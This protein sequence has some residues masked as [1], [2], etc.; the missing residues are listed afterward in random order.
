[1]TWRTSSDGDRRRAAS[2]RG[3]VWEVSDIAA[4]HLRSC[5]EPHGSKCSGVQHDA[6]MGRGRGPSSLAAVA[7]LARPRMNEVWVC[8]ATVVV[9]VLLA[10]NAKISGDVSFNYLGCLRSRPVGA[11]A[12]Q[13][14]CPA[15]SDRRCRRRRHHRR[16]HPG[17]SRTRRSPARLA[18]VG[19]DP[20]RLPGDPRQLH[21]RR[22]RTALDRAL[23]LLAVGVGLA[24]TRTEPRTTPRT[25]AP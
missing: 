24:V 23:V 12:R 9:A 1:M 3:H 10:V 14:T 2:P 25:E 4:V 16:L 11:R 15:I 21:R 18:R 6:A 7:D 22:A 13:G 8:L 19:N 5:R 20:L 17:R